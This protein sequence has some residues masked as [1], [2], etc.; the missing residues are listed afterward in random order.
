MSYHHLAAAV[1]LQAANDTRRGI[2]SA[3]EWILNSKDF[4]FY[5]DCLDLEPELLQNQ[6]R[7]WFRDLKSK[8]IYS[9][10]DAEESKKASRKVTDAYL[11]DI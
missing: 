1:I 9:S 6:A 2:P 3:R 10:K 5:M 8:R 7:D 4:L 11:F